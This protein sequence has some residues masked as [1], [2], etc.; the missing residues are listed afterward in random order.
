[1]GDVSLAFYRNPRMLR[2]C[3]IGQD[4]V[5]GD[6]EGKEASLRGEL[7]ALTIAAVSLRKPARWIGQQV[8]TRGLRLFCIVLISMCKFS[9]FDYAAIHSILHVPR[10]PSI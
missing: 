2:S 1:M 6:R 4:R 5:C 3:L 10:S 8:N 7:T 9:H